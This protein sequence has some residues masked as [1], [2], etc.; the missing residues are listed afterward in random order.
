MV[1]RRKKRSFI[2]KIYLENSTNQLIN[3]DFYYIRENVWKNFQLKLINIHF[4]L[5]VHQV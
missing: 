3:Q 5:Q 1:S 4:D 2:L